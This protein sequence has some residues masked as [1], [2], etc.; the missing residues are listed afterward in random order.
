MLG[1]DTNV[2]VRFLAEDDATQ[3]PQ[4]VALVL[5]AANQPIFVAQVVAV[6]AFWVLTKI[7]KFPVPSVVETYRQLFSNAS[8]E[9]ENRRIMVQALD[10]CLLAGCDFADAVI[11]LVNARAGCATTA[12]IDHDAQTLPG[13]TAV[14]ALL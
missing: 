6:E 11:A 7:R 4:A 9:I 14:E 1:V 2:L 3:T 8:F 13:M 12:T 5:R 10:D